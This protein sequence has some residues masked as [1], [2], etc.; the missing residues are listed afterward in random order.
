MI[1]L[2]RRLDLQ[3][4]NR[5]VLEALVRSGALDALG[6]NRAT[7]NDAIGDVLQL[8]ERSAHA[9][10]A[11]QGAL[12]GGDESFGTL[13]HELVTAARMDEARTPPSRVRELGLHLTGHAFDGFADHRD[14]LNISS[15]A[16]IVGGMP[17]PTAEGTNFF[18][19]RKEV[20]L[21]GAVMDIRRRPNRTSLVLD[22]DTDRIEA[23]LFDETSRSSST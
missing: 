10:A 6:P 9:S 5:R 11:G 17:S 22:D 3:K 7:L 18:A 23:T 1:D 14:R 4:I 16:K 12:F 15:I 20:T 21:A 19:N 8:A 13:K 2:C